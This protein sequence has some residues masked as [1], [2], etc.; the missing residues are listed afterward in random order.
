MRQV[1]E[2]KEFIIKS[3]EIMADHIHLFATAHPKISPS[4]IVKMSKGISGRLLLKEFSELKNKLRKGHLWNP[5]YYV[6][7]IGHI[8]EETVK[9]Y[10]EEQKSN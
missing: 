2:D 1:A 6:E 7:T 10:I 5:S 8:S 4:Y 9:K 3:K